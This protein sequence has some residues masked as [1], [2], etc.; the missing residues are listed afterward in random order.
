MNSNK[1]RPFKLSTDSFI[2]VLAAV[3]CIAAPVVMLALA[4][5]GVGLTVDFAIGLTILG[6]MLSFGFLA[7]TMVTEYQKNMLVLDQEIIAVARR[8]VDPDRVPQP[9]TL[10]FL[11]TEPAAQNESDLE[12]G[13]PGQAS[14]PS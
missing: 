2:Y 5:S 13:P 14:T 11:K 6:G 9:G 1:V 12:Q 3:V 4:L 7:K 8:Q 10:R